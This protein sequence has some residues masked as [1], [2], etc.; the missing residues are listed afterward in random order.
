MTPHTV[1]IPESVT[2]KDV[3]PIVDPGLVHWRCH[4]VQGSFSERG[5]CSHFLPRGTAS[6]VDCAAHKLLRQ[7][8]LLISHLDR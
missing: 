2:K 7:C 3:W 5:F 1:S 4:K 8:L 6:Y